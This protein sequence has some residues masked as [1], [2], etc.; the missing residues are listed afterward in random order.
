M[1]PFDWLDRRP[2]RASLVCVV[3]EASS[4]ESKKFDVNLSLLLALPENVTKNNH[5]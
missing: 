3:G 1:F 5:F 4:S 2:Y